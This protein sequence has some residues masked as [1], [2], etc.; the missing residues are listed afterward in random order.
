MKTK[1]L[2]YLT[3]IIALAS[4]CSN[5]KH[6][7]AIQKFESQVSSLNDSIQE[8]SSQAR[9]LTKD[10]KHTQDQKDSLIALVQTYGY[11]NLLSNID[12][13]YAD[14][15][16]T[17]NYGHH[18]DSLHYWKRGVYYELANKNEKICGVKASIISNQLRFHFIGIEY[19]K[20]GNRFSTSIYELKPNKTLFKIDGF[21]VFYQK[22][23]GDNL[24]TYTHEYMCLLLDNLVVRNG[25]LYY[26]KI[27]DFDTRYYEVEITDKAYYEY[28]IGSE[29]DPIALEA[30]YLSDYC[31]YRAEYA[32]L[33]NPQKTLIAT[34]HGESLYF[35]KI[36]HWTGDFEDF[37]Y[38]MLEEN[39]ESV[40]YNLK[41]HLPKNDFHTDPETKKDVLIGGMAWHPRENKLYFDNS[42]IT[43][44]CIW[45]ADL[46]NDK[47]TK[48]IPEHHAIHPFYFEVNTKAYL[49]YAEKNKVMLSYN[50]N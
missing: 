17:T 21:D 15:M 39:T 26:Y 6:Q 18:S 14:F 25:R 2:L 32:L 50:P 7:L 42:G 47:L 33:L 9:Q 8:L 45:E 49:A 16:D 12:Y 1:L 36:K 29:K 30:K 38:S 24:E 48:I 23:N 35:N 43:Y 44:R 46:D 20:Q 31:V 22:D 40:D 19:F 4:S 11:Y 10:L 3:A 5:E 28:V 37:S 13:T 41:D 27:L 34:N